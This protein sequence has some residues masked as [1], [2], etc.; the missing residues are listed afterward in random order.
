MTV[1]AQS[2]DRPWWK[3]GSFTAIVLILTVIG[4]SFAADK[5][6]PNS[7]LSLPLL[8]STGLSAGIAALGI[9]RLRALKMGQVI[10][11]EGPQAHHNKAGTRLVRVVREL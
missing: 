4:V 7:Q 3:N 5:W 10:R 8:L 2:P 11:E 9:P 1:A 6:I